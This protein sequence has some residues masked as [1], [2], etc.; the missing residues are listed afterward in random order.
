MEPHNVEFDPVL[1]AR[2]IYRYADTSFNLEVL[3]LTSPDRDAL[4]RTIALLRDR[5]SDP[6][7]QNPQWQWMLTTLQSIASDRPLETAES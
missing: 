2:D 6:D 4:N 5:Y 1:K 3:K 7:E